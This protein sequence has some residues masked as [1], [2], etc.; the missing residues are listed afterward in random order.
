V[1][2]TW[3]DLAN[4][5]LKGKIAL[6]GTDTGP[7][8]IAAMVKANNE[9]FVKQ[10]FW[11]QSYAIQEVSGRA[12]LDL[13]INGEIASSPT[14][15]R[16]HVLDSKAQ[17]APIEWV[18]LNPVPTNTGSVAIMTRAPHPYAATLWADYVLGPDGQALFEKREYGSPTKSYGF[19]VYYPE[20]G[21]SLDQYDKALKNWS[22]LMRQGAGKS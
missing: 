17:G 9:D 6:S 13:I 16:N 14:I 12:L 15:Y 4:P 21:L 19:D 2:K 3:K 11:P 5:A 10:S 22:D 8:A 7:R 18:P 20:A 1:P